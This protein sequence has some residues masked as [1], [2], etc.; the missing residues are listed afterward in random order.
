[1]RI[2][3]PVEKVYLRERE[4]RAYHAPARRGESRVAYAT[5]VFARR[6]RAIGGAGEAAWCEAARDEP[7]RGEAGRD[8]LWSERI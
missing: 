1:L 7:D 3:T 5:V 6:R 8:R 2:V 4:R